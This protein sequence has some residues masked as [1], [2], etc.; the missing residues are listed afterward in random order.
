M[1]FDEAIRAHS[2]WKLKLS[3]YLRN[4]NG[5][6]QAMEVARDNACELGRWLQGEGRQF[7]GTPEYKALNAEHVRFHRAAA[8]VVT[9]ADAGRSTS[10]D[11]ALGSTSDYATASRNVVSAIMAMKKRAGSG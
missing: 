9:A 5:S 2:S 8:A 1:N 11:T 4:P 10:E 3:T 6:L 7:A